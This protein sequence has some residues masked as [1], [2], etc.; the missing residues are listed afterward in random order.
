MKFPNFIRIGILPLRHLLEVNYDSKG[1]VHF[2]S[3][4]EANFIRVL[5]EFLG[6]KYQL[7]ITDDAEWGQLKDDGNWTGIIGLVHRNEAD[8]AIAH[9]TMSPERSSV[10]DFLFY[11]V[12]E[13]SFVTNLPGFV[14][15]SLFYLL[16]FHA[17]IWISIIIAAVFMPFLF[18]ILRIK[19]LTFH[20]L[21]FRLF[22]ILLGQ[23]GCIA[24]SEMKCRILIGSWI[25]FSLI[26]SSSYRTV[27][28]STMM[29]PQFAHD[30][31]NIKE[32]A[33]AILDGEYKASTSK[34]SVDKELLTR[35]IDESLQVIGEYI[36][37]E[38]WF[39]EDNIVVAPKYI[40]DFTAVLGPRFFFLLEY[41]EPPYTTKR[42]FK[43]TISFWNVGLA[44][45]KDFCCKKHI[46]K[47]IT[48]ILYTGIYEKFY[49]DE[50][51]KARLSFNWRDIDPKIKALTLTDLV[52]AFIMLGVGFCIAFVVL[53]IEI[54]KVNLIIIPCK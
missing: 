6:F 11:T 22:S 4:V 46:E 10:A 3:G 33:G 38:S 40:E 14:M 37:E 20:E 13:N 25:I 41:G 16:P 50:L 39:S 34:G 53:L 19:A 43:E 27:L 35:S 28:L 30:V 49:E 32:L 21:L 26:I 47:Y 31:R 12:E 2:D 52:G 29:V 48:R 15:K 24:S 54:Q 51:F 17:Y 18:M 8:I 42:I 45:R 36:I 9:L 5:S 7:V 1:N 23:Q 44:I